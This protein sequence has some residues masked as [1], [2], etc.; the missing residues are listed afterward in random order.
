MECMRGPKLAG[1][2]SLLNIHLSQGCAHRPPYFLQPAA[3]KLQHEKDQ[4]QSTDNFI[5]DP[6]MKP[7]FKISV[8]EQHI[9][10]R[11]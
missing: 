5:L 6:E 7:I 11:N 2:V 10:G 3:K 8:G 9:A 1:D 4:R